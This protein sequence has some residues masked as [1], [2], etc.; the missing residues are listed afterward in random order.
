MSESRSPS[1]RLL[2][3]IAIAV[4]LLAFVPSVLARPAAEGGPSRVI[5]GAPTD[6]AAGITVTGEARV[7]VVPDMATV[8]VGTEHQAKTAAEALATVNERMASVVA[9][10]R[11]LGIDER[12]LTTQSVY[13]N[14]VYDYGTDGR[15]PTL[16]GYQASQTLSAKVR[17]I[18]DAGKVIDTAVGAGATQVGGISFE[19]ADPTAATDQA[20]DAAVADA[21]R[22]AEALAKAAGI[23]VGD[24]VAITESLSSPPSPIYREVAPAAADAAT[25][26][27]PGTTEVMVMVTVTYEI[28]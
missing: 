18:D 12:D 5:T 8:T 3:L 11:Q 1:A 13:V 20:R 27:L 26:V 16:V 17:D 10:L 25:R 6:G 21:K 22:R 23:G 14:P 2:A 24:V 4:A 9:A 7:I 15:A 19:V 28:T